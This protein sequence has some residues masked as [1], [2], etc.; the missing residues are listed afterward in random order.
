LAKIG[1]KR[2]FQPQKAGKMQAV[3]SLEEPVK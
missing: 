1:K 2:V 3:F